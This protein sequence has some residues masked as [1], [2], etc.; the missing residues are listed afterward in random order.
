MKKRMLVD[1]AGLMAVVS[2]VVYVVVR[3]VF[4]GYS[5]Y[6]GPDM[7]S[8]LLLLLGEFFIIVHGI[9][10]ILN[11]SR[12]Y[13]SDKIK[14]DLENRAHQKLSMEPS[15]A[16]VVAARHEPKKVLEDTLRS[17][18]DLK[19][20]NKEVYLLDDST[21]DKYKK[22]AE[23]ITKD[24]GVKLFR[25]EKR[26]GAKAGII[27]DC[28]KTLR[29]KYI[30]IFDADQCPLPEFLNRIVPIMESDEKLAFVQTPQFYTNAGES[31]VA[32]AA[33][34]QQAVFYEYICG[35]KSS[36]EAMFCCGTNIVFRKEAL[37]EV[38]GFDESTVTEDFA[39]SLKLHQKK[40]R[41]LYYNHTCA[42][43]M[44]PENLTGY[45]KQQY[46]WANGT[47]SVLKK[48][49]IGLLTR[50]FSLKFK[51]W[52][53]YFLSG[54]YYL[55][56]FAF[57]ILML[58]PVMYLLFE[59][60]SFFIRP[61]IYILTFLP[62]IMLSMT[63]FYTVLRERNYTVKDIFIGQLLGSVTFTVYLRAAA[64]SFFG[65]R[66]TFGITEKTKGAAVPYI[67]LWPQLVIL[68]VSYCSVVWG[69]NRFIYEKEP[70]ILVNIFWAA[71]H[72]LVL[73]SIFY[74]NRAESGGYVCK[75]PAKEVSFDYKLVPGPASFEGLSRDTW[76]CCFKAYTRE[77]V[78]EGTVL[79]CK[80]GNNKGETVVFDGNV[81]EISS[82]RT[83]RGYPCK[84]GVL[85]ISEKDKQILETEMLR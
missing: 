82:K 47:I 20:R 3:A 12:A 25:R 19:Y 8:A 36:Q 10:Y 45:L 24:L 11:V 17:L 37:D 5:G 60:P 28:L 40:W 44:A 41:S 15:V 65:I 66:T 83:K 58:F 29:H 26:H 51:Q 35:G 69:F 67:R 21:D 46:R 79:M 59:I 30:A 72:C 76:T 38:G 16:V 34:F 2:I 84:I 1:A 13:N 49:L 78:D 31:R 32:K 68:L 71:Y 57:F 64:S 53:E 70:A 42:F 81:F 62:Y 4:V 63:V 7:A 33:T 74:F 14:E 73:S 22:E 50:P 77:R 48:V 23:E 56:G 43:G 39:T 85:T 6:S 80:M 27:N 61:E 75:K 52:W 54:S 9:G 18:S 55:V